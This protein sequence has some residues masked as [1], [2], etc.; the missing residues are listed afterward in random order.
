MFKKNTTL[1]RKFQHLDTEINA[2]N[3][4]LSLL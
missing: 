3:F 2:T 4:K 1:K